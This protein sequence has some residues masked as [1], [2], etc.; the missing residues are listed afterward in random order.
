[1]G[2][3]LKKTHW[4]EK[5]TK[6]R[7]LKVTLGFQLLLGCVVKGG[8]PQGSLLGPIM[9]AIDSMRQRQR[10]SSSIQQALNWPRRWYLPLNASKSHHLSIGGPLD[11][12]LILS[13]EAEGKWPVTLST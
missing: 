9:L 1:M 10:L 13:K 6:K 3:H 7:T 8:M 11:L 4:V 5:L 12:R 2:T